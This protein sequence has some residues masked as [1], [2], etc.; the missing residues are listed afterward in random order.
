[1]T[2]S[3]TSNSE[4]ASALLEPPPSEAAPAAGVE[5]A[6]QVAPEGELPRGGFPWAFAG[7]I[8]ILLLVEYSIR[9][10]DP[11]SVI[12]YQL[13]EQEHH[14][15]AAYLDAV[16]PADVCFIG[17]SHTREGVIVGELQKRCRRA[18]LPV[19]VANYGVSGARADG[20]ELVANRILAAERK[21]RLIVCG[22]SPRDLRSRN[23]D[24]TR[25]AIFWD[26]GDWYRN[27]PGNPA[28]V[29]PLFPQVLRQEIGRRYLTLRYRELPR[30]W[31]AAWLGT[32]GADPCSIHGD[33]LSAWHQEERS[34]KTRA[35]PEERMEEYLEQNRLND[36]SETDGDR[37]EQAALVR[38]MRACRAAGV[39][40]VLY[41]VPM[42]DHLAERLAPGLNDKHVATL[43]ELARREGVRFVRR[44][45]F[46]MYIGEGGFREHS[47]LNHK[48]ALKLTKEMADIVV[49][50]AL[51]G[52]PGAIGGADDER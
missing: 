38:L 43:T 6:A 39:P 19:E 27:L 51:K 24:W 34:L 45:E 48:G 3:S 4:H 52:T 33:E 2:R 47:H 26:L 22:V 46:R 8:L 5:V 21:P 7:A 23:P 18:G 28:R 37:R 50:P 29:G 42:S 1:M 31:L 12:P 32:V 9:A 10:A 35:V 36:G 40:L 41:E 20:A 25:L 13:G 17:S 49:I 30:Y 14:A 15:V 44:E 16:G 11:K